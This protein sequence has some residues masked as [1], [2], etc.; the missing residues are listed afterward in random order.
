VIDSA[1]QQF[2]LSN[3]AYLTRLASFQRAG[4][5]SGSATGADRRAVGR[6]VVWHPSNPCHL[7]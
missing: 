5:Y 3:I 7:D 2:F 6:P 4:I 1:R